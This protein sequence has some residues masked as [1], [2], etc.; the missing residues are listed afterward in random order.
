M[1]RVKALLGSK[2]KK[3]RKSEGVFISDGYQAIKSAL[4]PGYESAPT[5]EKIYVTERGFAKLQSE[6]EAHDLEKIDLY[7]V[8]DQVMEAMSEAESSQGVLALCKTSTYTF[9]QLRAEAIEKQS[10][11]VA[12]FWQLQDPGNAGTVLRSADAFGCDAVLFSPDSVDVYSPKTVRAT[13]G[14]LWNIP[15]IEGVELDDFRKLAKQSDTKIYAF[16]A[17]GESSL[18][19]IRDEN[20]YALLFGNEARGLPDLGEL[21]N[22]ED[23]ADITTVKIPMIGSTESLNVASAATIALFHMSLGRL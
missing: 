22:R 11:K 4:Q 16:D 21:L 7:V 18:L 10:M 12:Y 6:I 8:S 3:A 1:E 5:I 2:G 23:S 20:N 19:D 13:V 15:A 9:Q 14:S 17:Q